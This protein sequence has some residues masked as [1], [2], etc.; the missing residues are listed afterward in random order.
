MVD[1]IDW[2]ECPLRP[3]KGLLTV[4]VGS[5][6]EVLRFTRSVFGV[7]PI[8]CYDAIARFAFTNSLFWFLCVCFGME[9]DTDVSLGRSRVVVFGGWRKKGEAPSL[10]LCFLLW[11]AKAM[12]FSGICSANKS[13]PVDFP[14]FFLVHEVCCRL[15]RGYSFRCSLRGR[16]YRV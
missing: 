3:G 1:E 13:R 4:V 15:R 14:P 9:T 8:S 5:G 6:V 7:F 12:L 2:W 10:L 16:F 11:D